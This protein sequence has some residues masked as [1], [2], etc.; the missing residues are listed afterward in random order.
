MQ[1]VN[2]IVCSIS[3]H[4]L[5]CSNNVFWSVVALY[6]V[7]NTND[8]TT[9]RIISNVN[10]AAFCCCLL[11]LTVVLICRRW[12]ATWVD[13]RV[14]LLPALWTVTTQCMTWMLTHLSVTRPPLTTTAPSVRHSDLLWTVSRLVPKLVPCFVPQFW[15]YN[16]MKY[17]NILNYSHIWLHLIPIHH[18][19][20]LKAQRTFDKYSK[21]HQ[22]VHLHIN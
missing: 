3:V 14:V 6:S 16:D 9:Y 21:K 4:H 10:P 5:G 12:V 19:V 1:F 17:W 7:R 15:E 22:Y 11:K 2:S 13:T 18:G 20:K 8:I